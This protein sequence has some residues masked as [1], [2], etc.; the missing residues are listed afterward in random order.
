MVRYVVK[1]SHQI[2]FP[3]EEKMTKKSDFTKEEWALVKDG[4][5]WIFAALAAADG[6]VAVT[7]KMKESKAFKSRIT[8]PAAN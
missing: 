5:E 3:K 6:N 1:C 8:V 2:D 7:T 4:P